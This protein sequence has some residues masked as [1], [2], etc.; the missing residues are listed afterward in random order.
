VPI[1][2]CGVFRSVLLKY[3]SFLGVWGDAGFRGSFVDFVLSLG[4]DVIFLRRLCQKVGRFCLSVGVWSA[5]LAGW[6][7]LEGCLRIMK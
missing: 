2:G 7:G 3:P 5:R 6:H 4:K 1:A